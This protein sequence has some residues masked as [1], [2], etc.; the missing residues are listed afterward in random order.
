MVI[1]SVENKADWGA[2]SHK[3]GLETPIV[4]RIL[5]IKPRLGSMSQSHTMPALTMETMNG[6]ND[7]VVKKVPNRFFNLESEF[8]IYKSISSNKGT[9]IMANR[10]VINVDCHMA[11]RERRSLK[12]ENPTKSRVFNKKFTLQNAFIKHNSKGYRNTNKKYRKEGN[13]NRKPVSL[14]LFCVVIKILIKNEAV[15]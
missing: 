10:R 4:R 9:L 15:A 5:L 6:M 11:S 3:G 12:L 2:L 13:T 1:G 7:N 14:Y 8:A